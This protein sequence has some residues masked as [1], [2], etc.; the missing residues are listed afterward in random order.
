MEFFKKLPIPISGLMLGSAALGNLVKSYGDIYRN[1]FGLISALIFVCL[2]IKIVLFPKSI[3]DGLNNP[4]V[5]GVMAT[6]PMGMMILSTY[7]IPFSKTFSFGFWIA[8]IAIHLLLIIAFTLKY[9]FKFNIKKVFTVYYIV[10]VGVVVASVS[11]PAHQMLGIGRG[12]FWFG[13]ISYIIL[14]PI[15]LYR[16]LIVKEI[17]AIAMPTL[18]VQA[19]PG[20]LCLAGYLSSFQV[21]NPMVFNVL[22]FLA[23]IN[24]LFA[25]YHL[26]RLIL[27]NFVPAFSAF[28]FPLVISAISLKMS[29]AY[30]SN[31]GASN[32][33]LLYSVKFLELLSVFIVVFVLFR[34]IQDIAIK[35]IKLPD[36]EM[37]IS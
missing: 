19:A 35:M 23:V 15:V 4:V 20:S 16:I 8:G 7:T 9:I 37:N 14:L 36:S 26:P 18:I 10:Y 22:L 21:I 33:L 5:A 27:A 1:I 6:F 17:P 24:I 12:L 2:L 25:L 3:S 28:T 11:A 34:Y 31:I 30:L 29:N 13:F 32:E